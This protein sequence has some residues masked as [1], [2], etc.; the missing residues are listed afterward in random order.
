MNR[1]FNIHQP[2]IWN[3]IVFLLFLGFHGSLFAQ[4]EF[5]D[6]FV[7]T[8][9]GDTLHGQVSL[10]SNTVNCQKCEFRENPDVPIKTYLPGEIKAY[11][12]KDEKYY[13]SKEIPVDSIQEKVFLEYL[14]N[15]IV[16]LYYYKTLDKEYFFMEKEGILYPL[17][18]EK[19][20]VVKDTLT[21]LHNKI[22]NSYLIESKKYL[23]ML[24]F[25]FRDAKGLSTDIR[26]TRFEY[27]SLIQLT[28]KYHKM[29]CS[30]YECISYNRSTRVRV[31]LEP[32]FAFISSKL[33]LKD[34]PGAAM[35][36]GFSA[37]VNFRFRPVRAYHHWNMLVGLNFAESNFSGDYTSEYFTRYGPKNYRV[38]M[39]YSMLKVPLMLDYSFITR[40]LQPFV[41]AG[42]ENTFLFQPSY[43]INQVILEKIGAV[44]TE[45]I[46]P[47]YED[48]S[49]FRRYN[50]GVLAAAGLRYNLN[51]KLYLQ[52]K[53]EY[54]YRS[55]VVNLGNFFDYFR[56]Q[57]L[58]GELALGINLN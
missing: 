36:N 10:A 48:Y 44:Q 31:A 8:N 50:L 29:V 38:R 12:I 40:K 47:V 18:N 51:K 35:D 2:L 26:N 28:R 49:D 30:E 52:G 27:K 58:M 1:K 42:L 43:S 22:T 9:A 54:Q 23:G 13:V 32:G 17:T 37:G 16:D 20:V 3:S 21:A 15:G 57:S 45:R 46:I 25:L 39:Q 34:G 14:V 19:R 4:S 53:L 24:N 7:I 41:S 5:R 33:I 56:V 6:G 11:R 55:P